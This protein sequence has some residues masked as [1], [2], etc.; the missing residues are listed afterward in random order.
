MRFINEIGEEMNIADNVTLS[1]LHDMGVS[2]SLSEESDPDSQ[3]WID[4]YEE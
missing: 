3:I 2:V 1:E 4:E